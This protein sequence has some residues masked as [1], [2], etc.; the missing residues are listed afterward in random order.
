[1]KKYLLLA[2]LLGCEPTPERQLTQT[3]YAAYNLC[4]GMHGGA[5]ERHSSV[6]SEDFDKPDIY[7]CHVSYRWY[8]GGNN[9]PMNHSSFT[10]RCKNLV[11]Q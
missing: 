1:M 2:F 4:Q 7:T 10:C 11:C 5:C 9:A 3:E 6:C 8:G